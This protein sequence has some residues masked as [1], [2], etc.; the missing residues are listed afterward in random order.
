[1]SFIEKPVGAVYPSQRHIW[2]F[3]YLGDVRKS[4][5]FPCHLKHDILMAQFAGFLHCLV[6][7]RRFKS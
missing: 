3:L 7:G 6:G 4:H 1:M 5:L 2:L